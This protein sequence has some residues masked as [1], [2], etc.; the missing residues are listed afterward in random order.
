MEVEI[1][2]AP[3]QPIEPVEPAVHQ[4]TSEEKTLLLNLFKS[5]ITIGV[6]IKTFTGKLKQFIQ[7]FTHH[8]HK[9][10]FR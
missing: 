1:Q 4:F 7:G 2:Q 6:P 8:I 10:L 3:Q 9:Q 5:T